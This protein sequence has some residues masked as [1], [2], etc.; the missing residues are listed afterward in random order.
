MSGTVTQTAGAQGTQGAPVAGD[1][2]SAANLTQTPTQ[3]AAGSLVTDAGKAA[4]T[5][6][7]LV[8]D[9]ADPSKTA[10]AATDPAKLSSPNTF[11]LLFRN[12]PLSQRRPDVRGGYFSFGSAPS[13]GA[14]VP[15][16]PMNTLWPSKKVTSRPFALQAGRQRA[17]LA[18]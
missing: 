11:I 13:F 6:G 18:R 2:V 3:A 8:T 10:Q 12:F 16:E 15:L 17:S 4:A 9:A 1:V 7:S 5:P 14:P